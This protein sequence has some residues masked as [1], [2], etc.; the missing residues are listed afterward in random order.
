[1]SQQLIIQNDEEADY[2]QFTVEIPD[3][4]AG[5]NISSIN[6]TMI[7][8]NYLNIGDVLRFKF[9]NNPIVYTQPIDLYI[10]NMSTT[11][12]LK[13][14]YLDTF[15]DYKFMELNMFNIYRVKFIPVYS[16]YNTDSN[17]SAYVFNPA[18]ALSLSMLNE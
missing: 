15:G 3:G 12:D 1:M 7:N 2:V 18:E 11:E 8:Q 16:Y 9:S 5:F 6:G 10:S 4:Y 13:D 17:F 14:S